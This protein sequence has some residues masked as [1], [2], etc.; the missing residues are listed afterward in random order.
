VRSLFSD[1]GSHDQLD[2]RQ[3][4]G[5]D[6]FLSFTWYGRTCSS[7]NLIEKAGPLRGNEVGSKYL[8][9]QR[10]HFTKI[11]QSPETLFF[12][13]FIR[14]LKRPCQIMRDMRA[15]TPSLDCG[16]NI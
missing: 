1:T 8:P 11:I 7:Q 6:R 4:L 13:W 2:R 14:V 15:P 12:G 16:N 5:E 9:H 10:G 3:L